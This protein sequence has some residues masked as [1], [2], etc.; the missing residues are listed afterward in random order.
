MSDVTPID[1]DQKLVELFGRLHMNVWQADA[2][3]ELV[4]E[5]AINAAQHPDSQQ[6]MEMVRLT[7]NGLLAATSFIMSDFEDLQTVLEV[8]N[9]DWN[10][11]HANLPDGIDI[12]KR[13]YGTI[14]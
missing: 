11:L 1:K 6:R 3:A 10:E 12:R 5:L 14:D 9:P 2:G 7:C 8:E 13:I 4:R